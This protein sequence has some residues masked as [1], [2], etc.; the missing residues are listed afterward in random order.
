[1]SGKGVKVLNPQLLAKIS[2]FVIVELLS[3]VRDEDPGD[4]E[5]TNDAFLD[6]VPDVLLRDNG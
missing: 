4:S 6:K 1:M 2:K 3:I 5:V